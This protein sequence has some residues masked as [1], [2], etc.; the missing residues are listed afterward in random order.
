MPLTVLTDSEVKKILNNLTKEEV[1][2]LQAGLRQS[3]HEYSTGTN[4]SG[5]AAV[6]QPKRTVLESNN[7]TTSL[8]MPSTSSTGIG[9]KGLDNFYAFKSI[10]LIL[11]Q[12]S[13]LPHLRHTRQAKVKSQKIK[14]PLLREP[15]PSCQRTE[16][17][18]V[19][20]MQKK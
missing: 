1:E 15:S 12:S 5:A 14:T 9:M 11:I 2:T 16:N 8:F 10:S 4:N 17:R 7:G 13:L 18:S 19:S 6:N 20:S 3:L